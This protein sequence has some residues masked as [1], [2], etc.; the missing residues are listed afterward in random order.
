VPPPCA[1][2]QRSRAQR[3]ENG[4]EALWQRPV[5]PPL[6]AEKPPGQQGLHIA[7][8]VRNHLAVDLP[9][10]PSRTLE[11]EGGLFK[12]EFNID[13]AAAFVD[14]NVNRSTSLRLERR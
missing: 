2:R 8:S 3:G 7:S 12:P 11:I 13:F 5:T 9:V 4:R 14:F 10:Q 6:T 1:P